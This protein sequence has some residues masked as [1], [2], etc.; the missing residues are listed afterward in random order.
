MIVKLNGV[1]L[2][3]DQYITGEA[4]RV[5]D[6]EVFQ[7]WNTVDIHISSEFH[8]IM[9]TLIEQY[10]DCIGKMFKAEHPDG[11][12]AG[13][14]LHFWKLPFDGVI[15][16]KYLPEGYYFSDPFVQFCDWLEAGGFNAVYVEHTPERYDAIREHGI[17]F[18]FGDWEE[19]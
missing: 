6:K 12:L 4:L 2:V 16:A 5:P 13:L 18:V 9:Q 1:K 19:V 11:K 10:I 3:S 15:D 17:N 8:N 7:E 14:N